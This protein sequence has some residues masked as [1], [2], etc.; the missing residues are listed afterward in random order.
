MAGYIQIEGDPTKWWFEQ[1]IDV[2]ELAEQ[3]LSIQVHAP[4][5][6]TL[7]LSPKAGSVL[8]VE[9]GSVPSALNNVKPVI[10]V[11]TP[12]GPSAGSPGHELPSSANL[13][14][15]AG[16]LETALRAGSRQSVALSSGTLVLNGATLAF[17]VVAPPH[18]PAVG[19]SVPHD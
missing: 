17:V 19:D 14:N 8:V 1:S 9:Q 4:L 2:G 11:P 5:A 16:Q 10:Y 3:S 7:V 12:G 6:G 15:L 18:P 13:S